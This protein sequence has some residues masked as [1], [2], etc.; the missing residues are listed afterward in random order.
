MYTH[1][2]GTGTVSEYVLLDAPSS[3]SS[4]VVPKNLSLNETAAWP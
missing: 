3:D 4:V 1:I 2:F